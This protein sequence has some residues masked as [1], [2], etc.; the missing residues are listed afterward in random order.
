MEQC[1]KAKHSGPLPPGELFEIQI[2]HVYWSSW[3]DVASTFWVVVAQVAI[4]E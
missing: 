4:I 3:I 1:H 2:N